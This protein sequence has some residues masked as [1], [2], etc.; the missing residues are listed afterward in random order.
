[1]EELCRDFFRSMNQF[2]RLK[3]KSFFADLSKS[4]YCMLI[5][6]ENANQK[7]GGITISEIADHLQVLTPAVS[8]SLRSLEEK[9]LVERMIR[10]DDR[11]NTY[12]VLT[13]KGTQV[14]QRAKDNVYDFMESVIRQMDEKEIRQLIDSLNHVYQISEA[15]IEKRKEKN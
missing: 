14:L 5:A 12:V 4:E 13:E 6:I 2:T 1:M 10:K 9:E 11:R 3:I 15:E 8:R 7:K